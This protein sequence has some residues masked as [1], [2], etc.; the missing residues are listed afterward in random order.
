MSAQPRKTS[1]RILLGVIILAALTAAAGGYF[2]LQ[3]KR[4]AEPPPGPTL[5][6]M[7]E[8]VTNLS[9][10]DSRR[11]VKIQVDMEVS[12]PGAATELI[13]RTSQVRDRVFAVLRSRTVA[14][15]AGPEGMRR[16]AG[17]LI[18][19]ANSVLT[20]G[21]VSAVYFVEFAIQ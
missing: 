19:S 6:K 13:A 9:G 4:P 5:V 11:F 18:A 3:K 16:L 21:G 17:D 14:D 15:L 20:S 2:W 1:K 12:S 7:G 10:P 8:F